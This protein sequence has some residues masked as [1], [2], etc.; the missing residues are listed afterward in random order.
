MKTCSLLHK[1]QWKL[2][3]TSYLQIRLTKNAI[4]FKFCRNLCQI[5]YSTHCTKAHGQ[6]SWLLPFLLLLAILESLICCCHSTAVPMPPSMSKTVDCWFF[7]DI[8]S[9]CC[10]VVPHQ[11]NEFIGTMP[12][13]L[14]TSTTALHCTRN[15]VDCYLIINFLP[16]AATDKLLDCSLLSYFQADVVAALSPSILHYANDYCAE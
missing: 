11:T 14:A 16:V 9:P 1:K 2:K 7:I 10:R 3:I 5:L 15:P 13:C 12:S 8:F 6:F 4:L